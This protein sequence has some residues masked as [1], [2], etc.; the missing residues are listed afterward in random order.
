M[1]TPIH[2]RAIMRLSRLLLAFCLLV[3]RGDTYRSLLA[4]VPGPK[5]AREEVA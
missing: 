3:A 1:R 5:A 4:H 2:E